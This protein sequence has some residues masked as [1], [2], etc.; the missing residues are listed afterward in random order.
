M[1]GEDIYWGKHTC[2]IER[3]WNRLDSSWRFACGDV[4]FIHHIIYN[5]KHPISSCTN[6]C[7]S[8]RPSGRHHTLQCPERN[9]CDHSVLFVVGLLS[10]MFVRLLTWCSF[11]SS[12]CRSHWGRA[13]QELECRGTENLKNVTFHILIFW[14]WHFCS[15]APTFDTEEHHLAKG[16]PALFDLPH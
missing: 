8:D 12:G 16:F 5:L 6:C 14:L 4:S 10:F 7:C 3:Q 1:T 13:P 9:S 11:A 15:W 2:Q